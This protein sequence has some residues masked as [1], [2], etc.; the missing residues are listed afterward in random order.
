MLS[1]IPIKLTNL[2]P[3]DIDNQILRVGMIAELD[4]INLYEQ[5]TSMTNN[6]EIIAVLNDI[7][8]E[9]KTHFGEFQVQLLKNDKEQVDELK[10][11][12]REIADIMK[13]LEALPMKVR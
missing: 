3:E 5:L 13:K 8:K 2:A 6:K 4:A 9:E 7:T 12:E 11:A 1:K 10:A